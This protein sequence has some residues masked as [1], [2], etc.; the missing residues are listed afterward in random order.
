MAG[1]IKREREDLV[2]ELIERM[3]S[4][5]RKVRHDTVPSE[6]MLSPPQLHIF[7]TIAMRKG[8]VSVSGLAEMSGVTPG[9]VTQFVNALVEKDLVV[10]EN[11][12][13]DRRIVRLRLTPTAHGQLKRMRREYLTAAA[14]TFDILARINVPL[15]KNPDRKD[16]TGA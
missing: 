11:D 13:G 12:P 16:E 5:M 3:M 4:I 10:R 9:A 1:N 6:P 2:Q 15:E 7:F 14:R 8:G